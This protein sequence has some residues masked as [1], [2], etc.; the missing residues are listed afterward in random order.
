MQAFVVYGSAISFLGFLG[1]KI[2]PR[3]RTVYHV[4]RVTQVHRLFCDSEIFLDCN[5]TWN[6]GRDHGVLEYVE[7]QEIGLFGTKGD[8]LQ[9]DSLE[10]RGCKKCGL[11]EVTHMKYR[12]PET[13]LLVFTVTDN[14]GRL[15]RAV[16]IPEKQR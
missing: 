6:D 15:I 8:I 14:L 11:N 3:Y 9:I 1:N 12:V 13:S 2:F 16:G 7:N 10:R 4:K 5:V